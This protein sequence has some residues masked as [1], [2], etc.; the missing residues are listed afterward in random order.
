MLGGSDAGAHLDRMCGAPYTTRFLGDMINGRQ[1]LPIE[2][3]VQMITSEPARLF[4]LRDRGLIREG[5][6]ADLVLF[7]PERIGSEHATLVADLP[8]R[9]RP[10]HRRVPGRAPRVRQRRRDRDRQHRHRRGAGHDAAL[11]A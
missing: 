10:A 9:E 2:R 5:A 3:A 4:G 8:G 1:L 7:D 6:R 11:G